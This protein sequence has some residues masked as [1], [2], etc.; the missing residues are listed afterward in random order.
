MTIFWKQMIA[1]KQIWAGIPLFGNRLD[2]GV[3]KIGD[4]Y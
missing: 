3:L 4:I 2:G 1:G